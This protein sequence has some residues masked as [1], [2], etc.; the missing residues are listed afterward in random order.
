MNYALASNPG[1]GSGSLDFGHSAAVYSG[2]S[3]V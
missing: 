3:L 1:G 2:F